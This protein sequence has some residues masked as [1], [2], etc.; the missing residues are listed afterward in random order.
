MHDS[1]SSDINSALNQYSNHLPLDATTHCQHQSNHKLTSFEFYST[2]DTVNEA[3]LIVNTDYTIRFFNKAFCQLFRI[4]NNE[5]SGKYCWEV[6][7][8]PFFNSPRCNLI[9]VIKGGK[10]RP[11]EV[12][13]LNKKNI[14]TPYLL[15]VHPLYSKNGQLLGLIESFKDITRRKKLQF[16]LN[17]AQ[18]LYRSIVELS[19][20]IGEAIIVVQDKHNMEGVIVFASKQF[21]RITGYTQDE[22]VGKPYFELVADQDRQP[23]LER[24]R[25]K[26][27]GEILP[28]LYE[29]RL[30]CKN[31]EHIPVELTSAINQYKGQAANVIYLRDITERKK[32]EQALIKERDLS[33][34]YLDTANVI[35]VAIN[36]DGIVTLIN[37]KGCQILE[38][39]QSDILGKNWVDSFIP[40]EFK[41]GI[42]TLVKKI[43]TGKLPQA[44]YNENPVI[45]LKGNRRIIAWH[46]SVI[47]DNENNIIAILGSGEDVTELRRAEIH[48]KEYHEKLE[49]LVEK[50]TA[51]LNEQ[52]ERRIEF[53]RALV[54][55]L[56]TPLTA[57]LSSSEVLS[58]K[59]TDRSLLPFINN[60]N[61]SGVALDQRVDELLDMAKSEIGALNISSKSINPL[62]LLTQTVE[63]MTP[64]VNKK[65]QAILLETS[66]ILPV[67]FGD[68]DR[69]NQVLLNLISNAIKFNRKGGKITIS[70]SQSDSHVVFKVSDQGSG[71]T[72]G[73]QERIFMPYY[74]LRRDRERFNGLGLGLA[75]SKSLVELH[76]GC[77]WVE[78]NISG[79]C[80]FY[81]SIPVENTKQKIKV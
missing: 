58:E 74:R 63:E 60:I 30:I 54:H 66:A 47:M 68:P 27:G 65:G 32:M 21:S 80:T 19:S 44:E 62:T 49:K 52:I 46:N 56:K 11:F 64:A 26:M 15:S 76:G 36:S 81:F 59:I 29:I 20:E 70:A 10:P 18:E 41:P 53:T 33:R 1:N 13:R 7:E 48:L 35:I 75:L 42:V 50:R 43:Y 37:K 28:G 2:L 69:L 9:K 23:S 79:G 25:R 34:K 22:L 5:I 67:I 61:K 40:Q 72:V 24:H 4:K 45:T 78:N 39:E 12:E 71:I 6:L 16:Q 51:S 3:I 55:E 73:E 77:M 14:P 38:G 31:G 8:C 17:E 57:I